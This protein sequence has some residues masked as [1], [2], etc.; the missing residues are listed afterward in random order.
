MAK[1]SLVDLLGVLSVNDLKDIAYDFGLDEKG[2]KRDLIVRVS[3]KSEDPLE[4]ISLLKNNVLKVMCDQYQLQI[5]NKSEMIQRIMKIIDV[6]S[7]KK[8][9][10]SGKKVVKQSAKPQWG[11]PRTPNIQPSVENVIDNLKHLEIEKELVKLEKDAEDMIST[12]LAKFYR[13]VLSQFYIG[14]SLGLKIDL[15][16][17]NSEIGIELKLASSLLNNPTEMFRLIG[18]AFFYRNRR[19]HNNLIIALVGSKGDLNHPDVLETLR[20]L[21][22]LNIRC[23]GIRLV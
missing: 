14:G 10:D 15:D 20:C 9:V 6:D 2:N 19:Y 4:I 1:V 13:D 11:F 22:E 17:N 3:N 18:Q 21:E 8:I 7:S 23:V 12:F 16:I 5:G